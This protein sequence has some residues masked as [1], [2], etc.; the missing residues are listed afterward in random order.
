MFWRGWNLALTALVAGMAMPASAQDKPA[1]NPV[2]PVVPPP[3]AIVTDGMP[4]IAQSLVADTRPY[5]EYRTAAFVG[6][7]PVDRSMLVT[8]RFG[9]VAQ[10]H[11]VAMPGGA[12]KQITFEEEPIFREA[13]RPTARRCCWKRTPVATR[14]RRSMPSSPDG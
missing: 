3:A 4:P 14:W 8:T 5:L 12:R 2:D 10:L 7:H 9:N 11:R 1:A 6:W 13:G